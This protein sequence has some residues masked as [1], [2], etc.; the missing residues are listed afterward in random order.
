MAVYDCFLFF[1]E[2]DVLDIRL[3]ELASVV[4]K[5]VLV[6]STKTFR[7]KNKSLYYAENRERFEEFEDQIIHV[8]VTDTPRSAASWEVEYFQRNAM[9]RGLT[10]CKP[11][12]IIL[13]S[14]VDEIPRAS[15]IFLNDWVSAFTFQKCYWFAQTVS[16]Y[17]LNYISNILWNGSR[18]V[19]YKNIG[20]PQ[21]WRDQSGKGLDLAG[22]HMSY[23]GSVERIS[24]KIS[25]FAHSEYDVPEFNNVEHLAKCL[26][27]GVDLFNRDHIV[28]NIKPAKECDLPQYVHNNIDKFKHLIKE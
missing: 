3:H 14:D 20:T 15:T 17:Y 6:E 8:I 13:M 11:D 22:W 10:Q 7:N 27:K 24:K 16:Y 19:Q 21:A 18:V 5:F 2:L 1:D 23:L 12:D 25:A 26:E 9:V 28:F 4:D